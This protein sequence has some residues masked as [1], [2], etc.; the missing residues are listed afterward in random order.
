MALVVMVPLEPDPQKDLLPLAS[1]PPD[2]AIDVSGGVAVVT[3]V[4]TRVTLPVK[5]HP[6][7]PAAVMVA[8]GIVDWGGVL[9]TRVGTPSWKAGVLLEQ[10]GAATYPDVG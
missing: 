7:A 2:Q 8:L 10:P 5:L 4:I 1:V 6:S 3:A 9:A